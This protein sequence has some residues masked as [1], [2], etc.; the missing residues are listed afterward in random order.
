ME[1]FLE[2]NKNPALEKRGNNLKK[3]SSMKDIFKIVIKYF[4][5]KYELNNLLYDSYM[6]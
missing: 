4:N 5:V 3:V 2:N 1:M 6:L